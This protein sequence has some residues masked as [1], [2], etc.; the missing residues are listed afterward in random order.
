MSPIC[1]AST[2]G[3]AARVSDP[4]ALDRAGRMERIVALGAIALGAAGI[5]AIAVYG[6]LTGIFILVSALNATPLSW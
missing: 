6:C 4:P 3:M 5:T 2:T 1:T